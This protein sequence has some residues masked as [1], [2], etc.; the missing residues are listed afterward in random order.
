VSC[1]LQGQVILNTRPAHQQAELTRILQLD[2]ARVLSFPLIE[3]EQINKEQLGIE[4]ND[5]DSIDTAAAPKSPAQSVWSPISRPISDYDILLFVSRNAVEGAFR[6]IETADLQASTCFGVIGS[7][8]RTALA[9]ALAGSQFDLAGCLV[10]GEPYNSETLLQAQALHQ[11][12]GKRVLILRGQHGRNL[13]GDELASRGAKV[14]YAEVYRRA[15]P[16][17]GVGVFNQLTAS[18]F[19]TLVILTSDEGMHNLFKLVDASAALAL[20]RVPWLLISERMRESARKL[21][22][23]ATVLI[24]RNASD[25]GI[26]Q[27]ICEWAD[28]R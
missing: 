20:C 19:P 17:H 27:T 22:H 9:A 21:G 18:G 25:K 23:N 8:T 10:A 11:V 3:I 2:G 24:A 26:R 28:Q 6:F 15:V 1:H 13:L 7:A 5:I 12:A 16:R 4:S 14:E